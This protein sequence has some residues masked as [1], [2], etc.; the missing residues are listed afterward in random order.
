MPHSSKRA[1]YVKTGMGFKCE[2]C[3]KCYSSFLGL[4]M[5]FDKVVPKIK[6]EKELILFPVPFV[7]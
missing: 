2:M 6:W 4:R 7:V 1:I 3:D 5:H